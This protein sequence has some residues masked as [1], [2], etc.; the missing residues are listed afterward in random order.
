MNSNFYK[1]L[2]SKWF[3]SISLLVMTLMVGFTSPLN[4]FG[5]GVSGVDSSVFRYIGNLMKE[6]FIPYRDTFDHKGI[7]LY[8]IQL[9]GSFISER[10]GIWFIELFFLCLTFCLSYY[11]ARK[12]CN[13]FF[14]IM[15]LLFV[16][17][18][19]GGF[20]EQGNFTESYAMPFILIGIIV[21]INYFEKNRISWLGLILCG[22]SCAMVFLLRPN[23]V[24]TWIIF[25][26]MVLIK[27]IKDKEY[28]KIPYFLTMF[29][30]GF[31][32]VCIPAAI[33]LFVNDAFDDFMFCYFQFNFSYTG[34]SEVTSFTDKIKALY[35]F[36]G[37]FQIVMSFSIIIVEIVKNSKTRFFNMGYLLYMILSLLF[38]AMSGRKSEHYGMILLPMLIYP[39]C[40]MVNDIKIKEVLKNKFYFSVI[41]YVLFFVCGIN[42]L[43]VVWNQVSTLSSLNNSIYYQVANYIEQ[44]S[45]EKDEIIVHGN[46]SNIYLLSGRKAASKY[47]YQDPIGKVHPE[48]IDEY[49]QEL[50]ERLPVYI[51]V[52]TNTYKMDEELQAFVDENNYMLEKQI[53]NYNLYKC[54]KLD[55]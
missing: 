39:S 1:K 22:I 40:M 18:L 6:G 45:N 11:L 46:M 5:N 31:S 9:L 20:Y 50:S 48:I 7:V 26:F 21:F 43:Q 55:K 36:T 33:Y 12:Y 42:V 51:V 15:V 29:L 52:D 37:Y 14:S 13:R 8:F 28:F 41:L 32:L 25:P 17:S 35:F 54:K 23:M 24:A 30:I 3:V 47:S 16:Y 44:D 34:S 10:Y 2:D 49:Y 38:T 27:C 4:P 53:G 19:L